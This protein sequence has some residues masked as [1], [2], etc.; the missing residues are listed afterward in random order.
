MIFFIILFLF[1]LQVLSNQL[2]ELNLGFNALKSLPISV[3]E[4]TNLTVLDLRNNQLNVIP[5]EICKL[6]SL[7][8]LAIAFNM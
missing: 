5:L 7:R 4:L 8:Q 3:F 6:K 1:R 2:K